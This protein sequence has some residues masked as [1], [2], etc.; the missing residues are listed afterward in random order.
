MSVELSSSNSFEQLKRIESSKI[1]QGAVIAIIILS[2]LTIGAK[3][4]DLPPLLEQAITV[5]DNA[6]T[7][8][9]L[10]EILFR[11]AACP[12]KRRFLM[13]GW[14]LFDTLVVIGS[15]IPLDNSEAVLLGR[16]LRVFRVLRL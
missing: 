3:T 8:F 15:L 10:I 2:A 5:L 9:F 11:F 6:I 16:L 1:F 14:N 7:L 12:A 13:D 4:Y